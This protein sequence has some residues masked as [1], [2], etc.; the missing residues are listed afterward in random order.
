MLPTVPKPLPVRSGWSGWAIRAT[1]NRRA[2]QL[3]R[4]MV[5]PASLNLTL[6]SNASAS[7]RNNNG[8]EGEAAPST[9][10]RM[11]SSGEGEGEGLLTLNNS[12]S[13]G[14][15]S[16]VTTPNGS[17]STG[18]SARD[19]AFSQVSPQL[20][21]ISPAG[22][23]IASQQAAEGEGDDED[24]PGLQDGLQTDLQAR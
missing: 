10:T 19:V 16:N 3:F 4:I 23:Y 5:T 8:G 22:D 1:W 21:V 15:N 14:A 20:Q 11:I 24:E 6:G 7:S 18:T 2:A 13:L 12:R 17:S 9:V